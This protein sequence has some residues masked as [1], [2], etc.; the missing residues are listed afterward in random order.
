MQRLLLVFF[1][2]ISISFPG[3]ADAA[4][5]KIDGTHSAV[6]FKVRHM[7]VSW[8][9]GTF[10]KVSGTVHL[11]HANLAASSATVSIDAASVD[12]GNEKRDKHLRASDF[13]H[14]EKHPTITFVSRSV[15]AVGTN[16]FEFVGDLTLL[17][18]TQQVVMAVTDVASPI[19]SPWGGTK[20]G[21]SASFEIQRSTYGMQYRKLLEAGGLVVGDD[22]KISIDVE[23]N[24]VTAK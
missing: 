10:G 17:G 1:I 9:R 18:N 23:L 13:F 4:E 24:E 20:S 3:L 14:V 15:R 5:W 16:S 8:V 2:A 22:V 12:T 11:D 19:V 21:A 6:E 7:M